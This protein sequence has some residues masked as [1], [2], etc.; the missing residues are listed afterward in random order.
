MLYGPAALWPTYCKNLSTPAIPAALYE[1]YKLQD[2]NIVN[3][4]AAFDG[5]GSLNLYGKTSKNAN[6]HKR[7]REASEMYLTVMNHTP[8][9]EPELWLAVQHKKASQPPTPPRTGTG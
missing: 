2:C 4:I 3:D 7:C 1:Y 6:R 8:I 5:T 9:I